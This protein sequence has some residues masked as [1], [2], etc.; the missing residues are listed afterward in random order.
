M[1]GLVVQVRLVEGR[2]Y[3][4]LC[5]VRLRFELMDTDATRH[6]V[7][8]K[9]LKLGVV[10]LTRKLPVAALSLRQVPRAT[11]TGSGVGLCKY[12]E[13]KIPPTLHVHAP[14]HCQRGRVG[15]K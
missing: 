15:A 4:S 6:R 14:L 10:F 2:Q 12:S 8:R 9:D 3:A 1:G 11:V 13:A 5:G 7:Q